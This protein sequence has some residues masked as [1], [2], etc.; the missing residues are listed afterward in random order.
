MYLISTLNS[1]LDGWK[2]I[3]SGTKKELELELYK[4]DKSI[5]YNEDGSPKAFSD[6]YA[7][8]ISKNAR[9]VS[10]KVAKMQYKIDYLDYLAFIET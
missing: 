6:I 10:N 2:I 4:L 3:S 5:W 8:T 1:Q 9:I 7:D